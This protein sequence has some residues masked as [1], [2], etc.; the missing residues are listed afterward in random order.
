[1]FELSLVNVKKYMEATLVL[2]NINFQVYSGEKVGIVGINGSGKSTILKLIAGILPM[3]YCVGYPGAT[4]PGYDEGFINMPSGVTCAY[5]EQIPQYED[6]IKVIDV[7]KMAFNEVYKIEEE[8]HKLEEDMKILEGQELERTLKR[9]SNLLQLYEVK[10]GYNTEEKI[11][12]ICTGLKFT[13]SFLDKDFNLLSGGEKTTVILGKLLMDNPDILL[14]DEP[15]NHLDMESI[16]WLEGYL[17]RYEGIV[18]IVSHDRYFLDNVVSKI[19]EIEDMESKTYK[20]NYSSY[21]K[22][23]EEKLIEEMHN[24]KEQ[25]KE[26]KSMESTIK[27]LRDWAIRAD[28]SKFF[29]RAASME[30]RLEKMKNSDEAQKPK[31]ENKTMKLSF[32]SSERSGNETIKAEGLCKSYADKRIFN[33]ADLLVNFKE[34]VALIGANGSGKTTFLRLLLGEETPDKGIVELG[35]NVRLGYLPQVITFNNEDYTVLQVFRDNISI[36]EGQAR[37][38]LS[39]F[40]FFGNSVF[41]KVKA[42]SGGER[43]R[44]KLSMLLYEDI[45][46]LI[47]DEPTNHLDIDSIETFEEALEDF[48]G[49]IFFI[50][51]DRYF[52]NKISERV[53][54][55]EDNKF[56]SYLGNYD[57]YKEIQDKL[58]LEKEIKSIEKPKEIKKE[59]KKNEID[60]TKKRES[61]IKKLEG[62]IQG[63]EEEISGLEEDMSDPTMNY[64]ELNKLFLK[65]EELSLELEN[66]MEEWMKINM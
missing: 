17:N 24:Y 45:N 47:L 32:K 43:I 35:A 11:A 54:A 1:M 60:E 46:L 27:E 5:L 8:M 18:I 44:L 52:I 41:K 22:Q 65:K 61:E 33:E 49:T 34:R 26:I 63:L 57:Y 4:S 12:R 53:I 39:K 23:K 14:L 21:V 59:K 30:K 9:Y 29:K 16:E 6:G 38:Y 66:V 13:E 3:D 56:K 51:H 20:G 48:K 31:I 2:K 36:L 58:N 55:I 28:N 15:T 40:M 37:Q 10:G 62:R 19:I 7:L 64:E 25:Q 50:S 42:L